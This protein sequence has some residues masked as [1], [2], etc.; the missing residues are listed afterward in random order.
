MKIIF[1]TLALTS[2]LSTT[3]LAND[4]IITDKIS[5]GE[6]GITT[7]GFNMQIPVV[8]TGD[9]ASPIDWDATLG[10]LKSRTNSYHTGSTNLQGQGTIYSI[11]NDGDAQYL[12]VGVEGR[13]KVI[14]EFVEA[15]V[16]ADYTARVGGTT[17]YSKYSEETG[18][19]YDPNGG[20]N[21]ATGANFLLGKN[22]K[23]QSL[24]LGA[25]VSHNLN[26]DETIVTLKIGA[27]L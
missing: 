6:A 3:I 26:N 19:L 21:I 14:N 22:N 10:M 9:S 11:Q 1:A 5:G 15:V 4:L 20:L 12:V 7:Q 2:L 13:K 16:R 23:G 8:E 18:K 24:I 27:R 17:M 25:E